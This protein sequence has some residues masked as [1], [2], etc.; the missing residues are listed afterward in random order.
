MQQKDRPQTPAAL[1]TLIICYLGAISSTSANDAC[2]IENP[3]EAGVVC[4]VCPGTPAGIATTECCQNPSAYDL[5]AM[6]T[7]HPD[8]CSA[9]FSSLADEASSITK[10]ST[11][12]WKR[13]AGE[14]AFW[15]RSLPSPPLDEV[16]G[17]AKRQ[18]Y[19]LGKRQK[20]FLGKRGDDTPLVDEIDD[21]KRAKYFLGKRPDV[22]GKRAKYFLG[23]R[24][25]YFL[26]KREDE[27]GKRAK[28]FLGKREGDD[29]KR[30]KYFLGKRGKY[31]LGKREVLSDD[32]NKRQKYFLGKK[33]SA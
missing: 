23:K 19:F 4:R 13:S 12:F 16:N 2:A 8:Q 32:V 25:K 1:L 3:L 7:S 17:V 22:E 29:W 30:A 15:K 21:P 18:K 26:G 24:A 33:S 20:Y 31:F 14:Q 10:R 5:C 27:E 28:Y 6:C 11:D 9:F